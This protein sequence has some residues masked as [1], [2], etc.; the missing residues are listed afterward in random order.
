[1]L[2]IPLKPTASRYLLLSLSSP[3]FSSNQFWIVDSG[4]TR[5]I[6]SQAGAFV[7]LHSIHHTIVTLPNHSQILVH[8]AGDV[9]LHSDLVL[10]DVLFVPQFKFNLISPCF[11]NWISY[12]SFLPDYFVIQDLSTKRMIGRGDK[13]QDLYILNAPF[14]P[15]LDS[16]PVHDPLVPSGD[17]STSA[18]NIPVNDTPAT[19][20][21]SAGVVLHK[22]TRMIHQPHY[23]KD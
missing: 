19:A 21:S 13:V 14:I 12:K 15:D 4:A 1:M 11:S 9:K 16:S 3:L 7:S 23:L 10:K 22:S 18:A 8:F 17:S 6:C 5:H 20:S 2:P